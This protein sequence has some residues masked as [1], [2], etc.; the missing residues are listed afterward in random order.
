[1][2]GKQIWNTLAKTYITVK[3]PLGKSFNSTTGRYEMIYTTK[4][5]RVALQK[6]LNKLAT[7]EK[8]FNIYGA[9]EVLT[10]QDLPD[11][12]IF[13]IGNKEYKMIGK[14]KYSDAYVYAVMEK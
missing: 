14:A 2:I 5:I 7:V 4:M 3:V 13:I 11:E 6:N 9:L 12:T 1:M 10:D 8:N